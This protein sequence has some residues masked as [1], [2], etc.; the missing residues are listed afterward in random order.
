MISIKEIFSEFTQNIDSLDAELI[1]ADAIKKPREFVI[2]NPKHVP[3]F[4]ER[5]KIKKNIKKRE[6]R[7]PLA[8]ILGHK[9]FFGFYFKV[10]KHTLIPRPDTEMM[11]EYVIEQV[12]S[13]KSKVKS[14]IV[15]VDVGTGSGCIPISILKSVSDTSIKAF[16]TDISAEA[17]AVAKVNSK[18]HNVKIDFR[19]GN[20]FEPLLEKN[21]IYDIPNTTYY[22]TANLPYLDEFWYTESPSIQFEPKKALVAEEKG[23]ALYKELFEQINTAEIAATILVEIDPRH[24]DEMKT[25]IE[26]Q[27]PNS[28]YEIQNDLQNL[29]RLIVICIK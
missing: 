25:L 4:F 14:P 9:H 16:A 18:R 29:P 13:L 20:L 8:Y 28:K 12:K 17:L 2:A 3:S 7:I 22:I 15:L 1:I 5:V 26:K 6:S 19:K 10:N 23:T 21:T 11:V 27:F 24:V